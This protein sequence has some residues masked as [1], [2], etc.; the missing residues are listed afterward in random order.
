MA[1]ILKAQKNN[2]TLS[3]N[4]IIIEVLTRN[5][6]LYGQIIKKYNQ[7]LYRIIRAYGIDDDDCEDV[8]Q[9]TYISAFRNLNSFQKK[10]KFSTWLIRI[11]I[12]EC[13]AYL[14]KQKIQTE[15]LYLVK[16]E[17]SGYNNSSEIEYV[18]EEVKMILEKAI[19]DLPDKYRVIFVMREIEELSG[20]ETANILGLSESNVRVMLYRAKEMLRLDLTGKLGEKEVFQFGNERCN[21]LTDRVLNLIHQM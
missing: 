3:D 18:K 20:R 2:F 21:R 6:E 12:N 5:R 1:I 4:E 19:E 14:R 8:M 9:T 17:Y 10:S 11:A 16:S 7:R 13:L 15:R